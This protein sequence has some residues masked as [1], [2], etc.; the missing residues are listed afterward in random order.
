[1]VASAKGDGGE[2]PV[3]QGSF[4]GDL[5]TMTPM[6]SR[7][8]WNRSLTPGTESLW[9]SKTGY[10]PAYLEREKGPL[11]PEEPKWLLSGFKPVKWGLI[12]SG[13]GIGGGALERRPPLFLP[14]VMSYSYKTG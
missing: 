13:S 9:I 6:L 7:K 5:G 1:M 14:E 4:A 12:A 8:N 2:N 10:I 3:G 11:S